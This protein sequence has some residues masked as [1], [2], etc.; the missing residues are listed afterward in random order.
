MNNQGYIPNSGNYIAGALPKIFPNLTEKYVYTIDLPSLKKHLDNKQPAILGVDY[1]PN[2]IAWD[3]HY[4]LAIDC[5]GQ[6]QITIHDPADGKTKSIYAYAGTINKT[7]QQIIKCIIYY[8]F[9][10]DLQLMYEKNLA[11]LQTNHQA[12][13]NALQEDERFDAVKAN[14]LGLAARIN[15]LRQ[16]ALRASRERDNLQKTKN[17]LENNIA[18]LHQ[19]IQDLLDK[20]QQLSSKI[21]DLQAKNSELINQ[22]QNL[23]NQNKNLN[24]LS[25]VTF[26]DNLDPYATELKRLLDEGKAEEILKNA[27]IG[28]KAKDQLVN[29]AKNRAEA[30]VLDIATN[31]QTE[32]PTK[33][34]TDTQI[35]PANPTTNQT[36]AKSLLNPVLALV[37]F[38]FGSPTK[39]IH[40]LIYI[41][42]G[43]LLA[44]AGQTES[45]IELLHT[46]LPQVDPG[47]IT[48]IIAALAFIGRTIPALAFLRDKFK[49]H[50]TTNQ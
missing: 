5:D 8:T 38:Y 13:W 33:T 4:V 15:G 46:N 42:A 6:N 28:L 21:E 40:T 14:I 23:Q 2:S 37:R 11:D 30:E 43:L 41:I 9:K 50:P 1:N 3:Q 12:T 44:L 34:S 7:P 25:T 47:V 31:Q 20:N 19:Q 32:V 22:N 49:K 39:T 16:D 35:A 24:T 27:Y 45:A 29:L 26:A 10:S 36:K 48:Q 18:N 17:E